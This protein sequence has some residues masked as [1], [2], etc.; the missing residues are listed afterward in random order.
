MR[1][2]L[3]PVRTT[4]IKKPTTNKCQRGC[5]EKEAILYRWWECKLVQP[6]WRTVWRSLK[7]SKA[8]LSQDPAFLLLTMY[9]EKIVIRKD[10]CFPVLTAALFT[11]A[12][13]WKQ[14]KRPSADEG[15]KMWCVYT[16]NGI[17]LS[18]LNFQYAEI[19]NFYY[20]PCETKEILGT[21]YQE[22]ILPFMIPMVP[23][24]G[25]IIIWP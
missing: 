21:V 18:I 10:T 1:H 15:I 16:Y 7:N 13:T 14:P 11:V 4:I 12:K 6:L 22:Q 23:L 3:T 25:A 2:H 19:Q 9:P 17:L 20:I 5:G 8:Q 24:N